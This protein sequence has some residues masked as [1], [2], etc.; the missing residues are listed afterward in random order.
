[1]SNDVVDEVGLGDEVAASV[2][3]GGQGAIVYVCVNFVFRAMQPPRRLDWCE[4]VWAISE[5]S[6]NGC[7]LFFCGH[8]GDSFRFYQHNITEKRKV[9]RESERNDGT[10]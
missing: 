7:V 9:Q 3:I 4:D 8:V 10:T 2:K 5:Q 6:F 1:M